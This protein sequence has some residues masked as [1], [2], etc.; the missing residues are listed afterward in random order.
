M[1]G[2]PII[3]IAPLSRGDESEVAVQIHEACLRTGFFVVVGHGL[4][5]TMR[6]VFAAAQAFFALPQDLK[7]RTPR[8]ERYGFVPDQDHAIDRER[9]THATE[10]LDLGLHDEVPMPDLPGFEAA[11]RRY[12]SEALVVGA[13]LL[14]VMAV[15]L[16]ADRQF[17]AR[18][19]DDPQCRLRFLHYL[20]I[21]PA[22]D[23]TLA[24]PT[25]P[26]T[27]Y[28]ALTLLAVDGVPGLEVQPIG[29]E[30]TP[31][32]APAGALVVN[33]G[34]MLARWTNDLYRSTPHRVVASPNQHR[35]SV[36]YFVN[37]A[38]STMV[39][40]IPSCA[41]AD[42]PMR[43]EPILA[44]DYLAARIDGTIEPYLDPADAPDRYA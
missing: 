25:S 35:I 28:G 26:H 7:E 8:I 19:M 23:G 20:P 16:G 30:W 39:T 1:V 43:Y 29:G 41:T 4:D 15:Q 14:A 40:C 38:A 31:V 21:P 42:R 24:V 6:D 33:I 22:A 3:D 13:N 32:E 11:V 18:Q 2:P 37:P 27:D 12:Q 9:M 44:G 5:S 10:Y 34:D 17:F 36:P